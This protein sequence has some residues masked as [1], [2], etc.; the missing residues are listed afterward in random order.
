MIWTSWAHVWRLQFSLLEPGCDSSPHSY[1]VGFATVITRSFLSYCLTSMLFQCFNSVEIF[2]FINLLLLF[3]MHP[4][5]YYFSGFEYKA[6]LGKQCR[7]TT[8]NNNLS[9]KS[10]SFHIV[11]MPILYS[12]LPQ[13]SW[14]I[15]QK[16]SCIMVHL[17][18]EWRTYFA[19]NQHTT[20]MTKDTK[21]LQN[22]R[23]LVT[24]KHSW[25]H[26]PCNK[27][28]QHNILNV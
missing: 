8:V 18:I 26:L 15:S 24:R 25:S 16:P 10:E 1:C 9:S 28:I 23:M 21:F 11:N 4:L 6:A 13:Y 22:R 3:F 5:S 2:C 12:L 27:H 7:Y 20:I 17:V 14:I 19:S